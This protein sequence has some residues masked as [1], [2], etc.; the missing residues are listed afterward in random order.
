MGDIHIFEDAFF[1]DA[2]KEAD[3]VMCLACTQTEKEPKP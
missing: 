1:P 2:A 3:V